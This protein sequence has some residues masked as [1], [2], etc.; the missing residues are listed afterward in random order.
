MNPIA[1]KIQGNSGL[2][3]KVSAML[4]IDT[5]T[6]KPMTLDAASMGFKNQGQF[7]A[8]LHVSQN[9]GISF[10]DLKSAMVTKQGTASATTMTQT[11]SLGHAIQTVKHTS[12]T[13]A[14][15]EATKAEQEAD[16]DLKGST[17]RA[18]K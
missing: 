7:I 5:K 4:P 16:S 18:K 14:T 17:T 9:L 11:G 2:Y 10:L 6:G 8:T 15:V 12:S 3:S 13:T 1:M